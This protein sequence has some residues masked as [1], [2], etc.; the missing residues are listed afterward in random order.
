[1]DPLSD[2]NL[3]GD[4]ASLT[5]PHD[6]KVQRNDQQHEPSM[7]SSEDN[8]IMQQFF[9]AASEGSLHK[10]QQCLKHVPDINLLDSGGS[11]AL[12]LAVKSGKTE[13]VSLLLRS[14]ADIEAKNGE[15]QTS[16][17]LAAE[18]GST[19]VVSLLLKYGVDIHAM[20][21][22]QQTALHYAVKSGD[23]KVVSLLL[24]YGVDIHA[25]DD[26]QQTAL[27][28][29]VKSGNPKVVSLLLE[30]EADI[31]AK[32][33]FLQTALHDAARSGSAEVVSLLLEY[34]ADIHAK[35]D[36]QL[37][38][39]HNAADSG[40]TEV[41]S[42]LLE[43]AVDIH[44]KDRMLRTALHYAAT[45]PGNPKVVS[46]LLEHGADIHA[47]DYHEWTALHFA[48]ESGSPKVVS[49]LLNRGAKV[50]VA[51]SDGS[52]A[53]H[54][55]LASRY[56][57]VALALL[58]GCARA[59]ILDN[60]NQSP[61]RIASR[62]SLFGSIPA[63]VRNGADVNEQSQSQNGSTVL[64][65]AAQRGDTDLVSALLEQG[66][67]TEIAN[68]NALTPL[69]VASNNG[70]LG[71]MSLLLIKGANKDTTDQHLWT[72]L[73]RA[74][75]R[76][77]LDV[78][79]TLLKGGFD[80]E[81]KNGDGDTAVHIAAQFNHLSIV[82][83]LYQHNANINATDRH[84]LTVLHR[85]VCFGSK[86]VV[87]Y[88]MD[89]GAN[90]G[91]SDNGIGALLYVAAQAGQAEIAEVAL[92]SRYYIT[93]TPMDAR[94]F[95]LFR[96]AECGH[97]DVVNVLLQHGVDIES[98]D[99]KGWTALHKACYASKMDTVCT[100]IQQGAAKE[101]KEKENGRTCLFL[102]ANDT[103]IILLLIS[104]GA[105]IEARA[106]YGAT[107][108][109]YY[110]SIGQI[111][112]IDLLLN[113]G[114]NIESRDYEGHTA[115]H[116]AAGQNQAETMKILLDKGLDPYIENHSY[117]TAF[118]QAAQNGNEEAM[119]VLLDNGYNIDTKE[120]PSNMTGLLSAIN[121]VNLRAVQFLLA[122]G[123]S[124]NISDTAH[125]TALH[126]AIRRN[127]LEI[128]EI[129]LNRGVAVN[130]LN[131]ESKSALDYAVEDNNLPFVT[132]LVRSGASIM[133]SAPPKEGGLA[134]HLTRVVRAAEKTASNE[135]FNASTPTCHEGE[136]TN[137]GGVKVH[138][139]LVTVNEENQ[140]HLKD[141]ESVLGS[142]TDN[143]AMRVI[144]G[145]LKTEEIRL[146]ANDRIFALKLNTHTYEVS[147]KWAFY[148]DK[149]KGIIRQPGVL[150][151]Q[152]PQKRTSLSVHEW[153]DHD[154]AL[155]R[156]IDA[157]YVC[158]KV[159]DGIDQD[160]FSEVIGGQEQRL[161]IHLHATLI[162]ALGIA[163]MT[164]GP[165]IIHRI[166]DAVLKCGPDYA[167]PAPAWPWKDW[168][169]L[170]RVRCPCEFDITHGPLT[171]VAA[172]KAI[173]IN[174]WKEQKHQILPRVW[175][176]TTDQ[177]VKGVDII[178]VVFITHRWEDRE[179]VYENTK[180]NISDAK[181]IKHEQDKQPTKKATTDD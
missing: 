33:V 14:E 120:G 116:Y 19:E 138:E 87:S 39:I 9:T 95:S 81:V 77:D 38:A 75:E 58:E 125:N 31:N 168:Q 139:V 110:A 45:T 99:E 18:S 57:A 80:T 161:S 157:I 175:D 94:Q 16:L 55:A 88:L 101:A 160:A 156:F 155:L 145:L 63:L 48:A 128:A 64:L 141:L 53:L 34:G 15:E 72:M 69:F 103:K 85:A 154:N 167:P 8:T 59:D 4:G 144:A 140:K 105:D 52:T 40:N 62:H 60:S 135:L 159:S 118:H 36:F 7:D 112:A 23:P 131:R 171:P 113:Y 142:S 148:F 137:L 129:L 146:Y 134:Q 5:H 153:F 66:A 115:L 176:L 132:M 106:D 20:D 46:L 51:A 96:A 178:D 74:A 180:E 26:S 43:Y 111:D 177:L 1:M 166:V 98:T 61:L 130:A 179:V 124:I 42:L 44:A 71:V 13:V 47:K 76:G 27:H 174:V 143:W 84:G 86:E 6:I 127:A 65:E 123:A 56:E 147:P 37:T 83:E 162:A 170:A 73:H 152:I 54:L 35:D 82:I 117:D 107:A 29:A 11:T 25:M 32:D 165:H 97:T 22:S 68:N 173:G 100:L 104:E 109:H 2:A 102:A 92:S 119:K 3:M 41:V 10:V 78:V 136:N 163:S 12:H 90:L 70:Y 126:Y 50:N 67:N 133:K 169:A 30:Y 172:A 181:K 24:E 79:S 151:V 149:M 114:C 93:Q 121:Q 122:H 21:D 89:I 49:L 150:I 28:Y 164:G 17:H 158:R 91:N 108:L